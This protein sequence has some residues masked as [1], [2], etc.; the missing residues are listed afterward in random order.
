MYGHLYMSACIAK[1]LKKNMYI[2]ICICLSTIGSYSPNVSTNCFL[3][4][5][6]RKTRRKQPI[7]SSTCYSCKIHS[8]QNAN[9]TPGSYAQTVLRNV[10]RKISTKCSSELGQKLPKRENPTKCSGNLGSNNLKLSTK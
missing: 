8:Q 1:R 5:M 9:S 2:Y 10:S 6:L 3:Y 4:K 7:S